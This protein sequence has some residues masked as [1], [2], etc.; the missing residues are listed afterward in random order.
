MGVVAAAAAR[1]TVAVTEAEAA[2]V[3]AAVVTAAVRIV[4]VIAVVGAAGVNIAGPAAAVAKITV[5]AVG[6]ASMAVT[7]GAAVC[8][9]VTVA[10][11]TRSVVMSSDGQQANTW[12]R[13]ESNGKTHPEHDLECTMCALCSVT[14]FAV[15]VG[16]TRRT[17]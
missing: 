4:E 10:E 2:V 16:V 8:V 12:G 5:S 1:A 3:E 11:R 14:R 15:V 7:A 9:A 6:V 17:K 13:T